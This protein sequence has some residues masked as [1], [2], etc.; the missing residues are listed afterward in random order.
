M[1]SLILISSLK[2]GLD[3][4]NTPLL[5]AS[6]PYRTDC[7]LCLINI[8]ESDNDALHFKVDLVAPRSSNSRSL[9]NSKWWKFR[10][11]RYAC[12][13]ENGVFTRVTYCRYHACYS[14]AYCLM[15]HLEDLSYYHR[16]Y[17]RIGLDIVIVYYI[18]RL[19]WCVY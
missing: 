4:R 10:S 1:E 19:Q 7:L 5:A 8:S 2:P 11:I 9:T 6:F 13:F 14:N 15:A 17:F 12:W 16:L 18:C 3:S